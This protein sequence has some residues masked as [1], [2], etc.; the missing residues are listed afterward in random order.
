[1][2]CPLS[3]HVITFLCFQSQQQGNNFNWE[4]DDAWLLCPWNENLPSLAL[5][6]LDQD[7]A[8]EAESDDKGT[9][10]DGDISDVTTEDC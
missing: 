5:P 2:S 1:M 9:P 10:R 6:E 3:S 8:G 4:F 7:N